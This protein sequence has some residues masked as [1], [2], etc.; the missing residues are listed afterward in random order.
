VDEV[1]NVGFAQ[2][3]FDAGDTARFLREWGTIV[4]ASPRDL[5]SF[6]IIAPPR[7]GQPALAHVLAMVDSDQPET[8]LARLQPFADIAPLYDQRV[9]ITSYANVMAN[10]AGTDHNGQGEPVARSGLLEH[11]TPEFAG[12]AE[13]L[14]QSGATYFFQIRSVGGAVADI[15]SDATAYANRSANFSVVAFGASPARMNAAWEE[16][17]DHFD[18]LYLSFETDRSIER[19]YDAF[20]PRTLER[21]RTLKARYDPDN[22][23]RDN[24]NIAPRALVR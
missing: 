21:L 10:G 13:Q 23:F 20:P 14:I 7:G 12:I 6:L 9:F 4:E 5:T 15:D 8:I 11:I 1:G 17:H 22:V 19:L 16:L 18:G 24:F 2:L 3:V